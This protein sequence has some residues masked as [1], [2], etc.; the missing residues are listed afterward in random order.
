MRELTADEIRA[1]FVNLHDPA[2]DLPLPG[3]HEVVWEDREYLGWR[4]PSLASR[5][6]LVH[7]TPDG[8]V[9]IVLRRA[10]PRSGAGV[11]AMCSLC[12]ATQ[13]ATQVALWSAPRAGQAG[14]DGATVGTYICEDLG[15]SHI[16]RMLPASSPW[17]IGSGD[18]LEGRSS[19]LV[20][21]V[22]SFAATV[23]STR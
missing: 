15:C 5:G 21:R 13:P 10:E 2:P 18:L 12:H 3:L 4:D 16:I 9:G 6:Y 1:S 7:E 22:R 19:G 23:L 11:P 8:I 17:A 14:R 20:E